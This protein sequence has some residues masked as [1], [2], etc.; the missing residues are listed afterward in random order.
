[1]LH[2]EH[3]V[4]S[5]VRVFANT[6][7]LTLRRRSAFANNCCIAAF[8]WRLPLVSWKCDKHSDVG[9]AGEAASYDGGCAF[10]HATDFRLVMSVTWS[11]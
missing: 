9:C 1:M 7:A 4:R 8:G 3:L 5:Q 2:M 10:S 6:A 11:R